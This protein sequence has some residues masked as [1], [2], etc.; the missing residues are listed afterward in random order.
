M[1]SRTEI[2][3]AII[4][5]WWQLWSQI[6]KIVWKLREKNY[7]FRVQLHELPDNYRVQ[8]S[9]NLPNYKKH[10]TITTYD[11]GDILFI[12]TLVETL[13]ISFRNHIRVYWME[14]W[15]SILNLEAE[16]GKHKYG[17]KETEFNSKKNQFRG[18]S[19]IKLA[20]MYQNCHAKIKELPQKHRPKIGQST[21][22]R[23]LSEQ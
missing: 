2:I 19:G 3:L 20:G 18:G 1:R 14:K 23:C 11:K 10:F 6:M 5:F 21:S 9:E 12:N 22:V 13:K 17:F 15:Q 16:E 7:S 4:S 8:L